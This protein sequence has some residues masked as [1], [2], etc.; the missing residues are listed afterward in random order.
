MSS[1]PFEIEPKELEKIMSN[2]KCRTSE[3]EDIKYF[4]QKKV[5]D[6]LTQLKTDPERGISSQENRKEF[7]GS[8]KIFVE[9]LPNFFHFVLK[10]MSNLMII[11]LIIAAIFSIVLGCTI[12]QNNKKDWIDG[13]SIVIAIIIVVLVS[14]ITE[15]SKEKKFHQLN[16]TQNEGIKYKLIRRGQPEN[17]IN[18][19]I[20][21]GDLIIINYG[22]IMPADI[23]LIEGNG[24]KMDESSLTG[25]SDS[26][27]KEPY[28]KC[29]EILEKT[30]NDEKNE[31]I[32]SPLIL[33]GTF[34]I[35]GTGKGI[36]IAVG[37]NSQKGSIKRTV[38]NAKENHKTPLELK[39]DRIAKAIGYFGIA[40]G[41]ITFIVF[42]IRYMVKF[43]KEM[44]EYDKLKDQENMDLTDPRESLAKDILNIIMLCVSI[45][46][47]IV[48]EGLPLA[49]TLSLALSVNKLMENNNLV[50][51]MHACET[52]GGANYI[53]TDKTGTLTKNEMSV[54]QI[55]TGKNTYQLIQYREN[56]D[57]GKIDIKTKEDKNMKA[58]RE[59]HN[60]YFQNEYFWNLLK[61][62][63][64]LNVECAI[65]TLDSPNINGDLEI[66]ETKNKT[67]RPFIEF[68]YRF[69]SPISLERN[70]YLTDE[71][72]Y[73]QFP[74]D[75][76]KKRMTTFIQNSK[77]P[78]GYR[79]FTKGGGDFALQY[80]KSYID[81]ETGNENLINES[82]FQ[83][84][85]DKIIEY[86][87]NRL[88]SLYIAYKDITEE[89]YN[90]AEKKNNQGQF[91]DQYDL[92]FL[93]IF[94]IKDSLRDGVKEA[95][96]KCGEANV[97][98]IMITG[99]NI[100]T[101][102]YI[103]KE[104]GILGDEI[105]LNNL[106]SNDIEINCEK[107][108]DDNLKT[109]E[110][111]IQKL[112]SDRP[113]A[114]SGNSFYQIIG[115]LFCE[116]CKE[117]TTSCQC[118]K[119]ENEAKKR[120]EKNKTEIKKVKNDKIKNMKNFVKII[121]RL[122]VLARSQPL[123][124]YALVLGLKELNKVVA[125]T[126][127]GTNDAPALSKSDVGFAMFAGTDIAK[128]ASDIIILDNNFNSIVTAIIYG[129]NIYDNIRKFLQFQ[130]SV[131][132]CACILVFICACVGNETP[133][134]PIQMLW[135]NLIMDSLGS[136]ALATEPPYDKLLKREPT[137]KNEFIINGKMLKHIILQSVVLI[138][139]LIILYALGPKFIKENN[140]TR[141]KE[142]EIIDFCYNHFPG[143]SI[144]Y[145]ISGMESKWGENIKIDENKKNINK[146][147]N[148]K[149][150]QTLSFAYDKYIESYSGT[151]HITMIF[152]IFVFYTLFNQISCRVIDD[153][154]NIFI[155]IQKNIFFIIII[156]IEIGLQILII[157]FGKAP[158]HIVN[159][160][161]TGSQWGICIGFSVITF[162]VSIIIKSIPIDKFIDK[163]LSPKEKIPDIDPIAPELIDEKKDTI[164]NVIQ[165]KEE[166]DE[167]LED[168]ISEQINLNMIKY[169]F[170]NKDNQTLIDDSKKDNIDKIFSQSNI[171]K[172]NETNAE[173]DNNHNIDNID[174]MDNNDNIINEDNKISNKIEEETSKKYKITFFGENVMNLPTNYSTDNE[175]EY[176]FINY[177]NEPNDNYE[178]VVNSKKTKVYAKIVS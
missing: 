38:D 129:R 136:L 154:Y 132:F 97:N 93:C 125:V 163:Y 99:D 77:F 58:I 133:L 90:N 119:T 30:Q 57:V 88:R 157:F 152:N 11:I 50:R 113:Y 62:S 137:K 115:G 120:A 160:G 170:N 23:L 17:H 156:I 123:H 91:I 82:V 49:V 67:D 1:K 177:L 12:S 15:Y 169:D 106:E 89:E 178:L 78:T 31:K 142:N 176:K 101:A 42:F 109:K 166:N 47:V 4:D 150:K 112:L 117:E 52:M 5:S 10:G 34:C 61:I 24:I 146:C 84:I 53:C 161:L 72:S 44:K 173:K 3:L 134:T 153:S 21:V 116:N 100:I 124:K 74:F 20:L 71:N 26:I 121:T 13:V 139:I 114:L 33:S 168:V 140:E 105:D 43:S 83:H 70:I 107:M 63:I 159:G 165:T 59:D 145:I 175:D 9:P 86:N 56:D 174:N 98:L 172:E 32:P 16:K 111:Y 141:K 167:E 81:P 76:E 68:L 162:F 2:Y 155:R 35:E 103:A 110:K 87:K 171:S 66:C 128:E 149:D 51:K 148:Y 92:V 104:C 55:L 14:S 45:I 85:K 27:K 96:I 54:F 7:F 95:V 18:D 80:C 64:A 143:K 48:P 130:L 151:T 147:T 28:E 37:I 79:L 126:G 29:K 158:F 102:T 127:D 46:V 22:D 164:L 73:K 19:D 8:N 118:P 65:K 41:V 108:N 25:E 75:S 131:N 6:I 135:V 138:I 40:A 39:L 60:N 144:Q 122:K 36:V 94:G 69:K